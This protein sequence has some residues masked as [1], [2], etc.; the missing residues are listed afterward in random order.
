MTQT[1]QGQPF[2]LLTRSLPIASLLLNWW[3]ASL[4]IV[5][6]ISGCLGTLYGLFQET[7][8]VW[9]SLLLAV[10]TGALLHSVVIVL[11]LAICVIAEPTT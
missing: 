1:I 5:T 3:A 4:F 10:G 11:A 2:N 8:D 7:L 6:L 9:L